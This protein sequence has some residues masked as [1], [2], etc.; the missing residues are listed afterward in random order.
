MIKCILERTISSKI[1]RAMFYEIIRIC[2]W[3]FTEFSQ[4]LLNIHRESLPAGS[5]DIP[6]QKLY[7]HKNWPRFSASSSSSID[8]LSILS[9]KGA[10]GMNLHCVDAIYRSGPS[11]PYHWRKSRGDGGMYPPPPPHFFGWGDD[12]YKH[13]PPHFLKIR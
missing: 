6:K 11:R 3:C 7:N 4:W 13:P 1:L 2:Q 5:E 10:L 8:G 9:I 12:L